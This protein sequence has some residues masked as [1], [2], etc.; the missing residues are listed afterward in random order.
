MVRSTW[1]TLTTP[2]PQWARQGRFK[3]EDLAAVLPFP[4]HAHLSYQRTNQMSTSAYS[5]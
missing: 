1:A 5:K 4:E 2:I 3:T